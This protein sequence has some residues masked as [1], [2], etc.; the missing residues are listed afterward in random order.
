MLADFVIGAVI[1]GATV[2]GALRGARPRTVRKASRV[3]IAH[4]A[5]DEELLARAHLARERAAEVRSRRRR[6][7]RTLREQRD[8]E[9]R[10][11]WRGAADAAQGIER[12]RP[13]RR[14]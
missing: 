2:A 8:A 5:R 6:H 1:G 13:R 7:L 12:P 4:R 9:E 11:Y 14:G 3:D 10:A